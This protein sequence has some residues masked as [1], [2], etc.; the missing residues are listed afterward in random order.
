MAKIDPLLP[1]SS[2]ENQTSAIQTINDNA[3]KIESALENTLSLD[4]SS[5]NSMQADLD[6]NSKRVLN[7][8]APK[9]P[10]EPARLTDLQ[11]AQILTGETVIPSQVGQAGKLLATDGTN[12]GWEDGLSL[13][14]LGDMKSTEN[15]A[16][17]S[18]PSTARTNLGLRSAAVEDVGVS[19]SKVPLL[20]APN[21]WS[22][23]QQVTG[24]TT[25]TGVVTFDTTGDIVLNST[26][27]TLS[28]NSVGYR[29]SPPDIQ[30]ATYSFVTADSGRTKVHTSATAHTYTIPSDILPEGHFLVVLNT[31]TGGTTIA[32]GS[33]VTLAKLGAGGNANLTISQWGQA[34]LYQY[35]TNN[36]ILV[37][38]TNVT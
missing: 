2:L 11:D 31:G 21:I 27:A 20:N 3:V 24:T 15:L 30:N 7:L 32:R 22:G 29:G 9:S 6:M 35:S 28:A 16:D 10:T 1:L 18:N 25:V 8:P 36:W 4:G 37:G 26:T 14:G 23:A 38:G 33:G 34:V 19:G 17:L 5:P 12:L 13:P